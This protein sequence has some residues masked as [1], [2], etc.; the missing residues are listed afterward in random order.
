MSSETRRTNAAAQLVGAA[1][2]Q[3]FHVK[4]SAAAPGVK[5]GAFSATRA[6]R[7]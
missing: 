2:G 4:R 5:G 1:G 7:F 6:R 3:M